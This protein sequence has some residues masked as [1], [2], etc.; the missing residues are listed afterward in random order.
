MTQKQESIKESLQM[1][2]EKMSAL[3]QQVTEA[4]ELRPEKPEETDVSLTSNVSGRHWE[5]G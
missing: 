5:S 2:D 4:P 1:F 3:A